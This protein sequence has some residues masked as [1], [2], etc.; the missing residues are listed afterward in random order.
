MV[1]SEKYKKNGPTRLKYNRVQYNYQ[2]QP[3]PIL[4]FFKFI[5]ILCIDINV[6]C[7]CRNNE[8]S[9]LTFKSNFNIYQRVTVENR[10]VGFL[11]NLTYRE[12]FFCFLYFKNSRNVSKI[13]TWVSARLPSHGGWTHILI[14]YFHEVSKTC[15]RRPGRVF[16]TKAEKKKK[17]DRQRKNNRFVL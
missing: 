2:T 4:F 9:I 1:E 17:N 10:H 16:C 11:C 15:L 6:N 13:S 5:F 7:L 3:N 8:H 14:I 12:V